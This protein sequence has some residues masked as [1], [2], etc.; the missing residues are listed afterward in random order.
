[1]AHAQTLS[2]QPAYFY[3]AARGRDSALGDAAAVLALSWTIALCA[4]VVIPLPF[5]PVP[6]TG[7]TLGV[8]LA[9]ALLGP[10]R[11]AAAAGLY[12]MQGGIGLP[13]FAGGAAGWA[14]LAGPT[15]GYLIGFIPGA[16]LAGLLAGRGWDRRF[17]SNLA[18]LLAGSAVILA[19]GLIGLARF[20]PADRLLPAGL[21]PFLVG[22]LLK[23]CLA[24]ALLPLGWRR[25]GRSSGTGL[26]E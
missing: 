7:S 2:L 17:G 14:C 23:S 13:F 3:D 20:L 1:M 21:T 12:L 16:W 8:L 9:G 10:R 5:T 4:R 26:T 25:L 22:D 11:G 19:C 18:L 15:G 6:L 24:A